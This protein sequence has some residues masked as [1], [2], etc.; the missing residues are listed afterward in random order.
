MT[1]W[2]RP[3]LAVAEVKARE[4]AAQRRAGR[5]ARQPQR[6]RATSTRSACTCRSRHRPRPARARGC[7]IADRPPGPG[8]A[9]TTT[10]WRSCSRSART[11]SR[12]GHGVL[13]GKSKTGSSTCGTFQLL[14]LVHR[15]QPAGHQPDRLRQGRRHAGQ[16]DQRRRAPAQRRLVQRRPELGQRVRV[17]RPTGNKLHFYILDKRTDADGHPAL[18]GRRPLDR[19]APARRR[20][21]WRSARPSQGTGRGL[22]D[23]HVPAQ[24][25]GRRGGDADPAPAGRRRRSSAATSTACRRRRSGTGWTA[26]LKNA[27]AAAKFGETRP[28]AGLHREGRGRGRLGL[29]HAERDVRERSVEVDVGRPARSARATRVGG[30]VPATLA[31]TLGAPASF[32]AVHAGRAEGLLRHHDGERRSRPRVTRR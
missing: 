2:R 21:A 22:H 1:A 18:Q 16:G 25:H 11:P 32:G 23:L 26:H 14:R 9:S 12:P 10:R 13:I 29:G 5:R 24:E 28:G 8:R 6:R 4:V 20:A 15:L 31:L 17:R 7:A 19:A 3:G 30:T 27:L